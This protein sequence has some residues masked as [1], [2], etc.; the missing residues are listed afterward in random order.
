MTTLDSSPTLTMNIKRRYVADILAQPCR[1]W[2]EYREMKDYW[3][4]RLEPVEPAPFNLRLI[5]GMMKPCPEAT[6]RV[7]KV[8]RNYRTGEL[9]LHLGRVLS[10]KH[11]DRKKELPIK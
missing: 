1:K 7:T 2:I 3:L 6:I 11:W 5:N 9:E 4:Q 8:H 10:V